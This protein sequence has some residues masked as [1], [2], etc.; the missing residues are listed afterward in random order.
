[1][2]KLPAYPPQSNAINKFRNHTGNC[3]ICHDIDF[4]IIRVIDLVINLGQKLIKPGENSV[5]GLFDRT[6]SRGFL[7][8]TRAPHTET[9]SYCP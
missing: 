8:V 9:I 3:S 7:S 4:I 1:M 2:Y 5:F 6:N